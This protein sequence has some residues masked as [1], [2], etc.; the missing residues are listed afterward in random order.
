MNKE[1]NMMFKVYPRSP[2]SNNLEAINLRFSPEFTFYIFRIQSLI[3]LLRI[4]FLS[5]QQKMKRFDEKNN[6]TFRQCRDIFS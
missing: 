2:I 4:E 6:N 1:K 5:L 3:L